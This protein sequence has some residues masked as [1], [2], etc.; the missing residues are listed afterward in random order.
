MITSTL[1][2]LTTLS[3]DFSTNLLPMFDAVAWPNAPFSPPDS[4]S[5]G[6]VSYD[7]LLGESLQ[8]ETGGVNQKRF[9]TRGLVQIMVFTRPE[10]GEAIGIA[11]ADTVADHYRA[12]TISGISFEAPSVETVGLSGGWWTTRIRC[13][14]YADR[15]A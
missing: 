9:R 8:V 7:V 1:N 2:L 15:V 3:T 14:F 6:W 10:T 5:R 4:E 13:P 12:A 11:G